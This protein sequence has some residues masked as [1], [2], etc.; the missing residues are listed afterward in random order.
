M[1]S[2][3]ILFSVSLARGIQNSFANV[4]EEFGL[5][6]FVLFLMLVTIELDCWIG[7]SSIKS[8]FTCFSSIYLSFA[9][10]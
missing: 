3:W 6:T 1:G 8:H 10:L 9:K 7:H 5:A 2:P 4:L